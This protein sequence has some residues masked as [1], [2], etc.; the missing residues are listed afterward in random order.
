MADLPPSHGLAHGEIQTRE[1]AYP[2][3]DGTGLRGYLAYDDAQRGPRPGILVAPEFW[4]LNDYIRR[5]AR[6]LAALGYTALAL[7]MYG[8]GHETREPEEAKALMQAAT[9]SVEATRQRFEAALDLLL[10]QPE[11]DPQRVGAIGYC[12]GGKLVL[13]MARQGV[14]MAG[15]VSFHGRLTPAVPAAPGGVRARVLVEHGEADSMT[16]PEQLQAFEDEM[17]Q[18]GV[19]YRL[20]T[21]PGARHGFT[22]PQADERRTEGLDIG[23]QKEADERSWEDMKA[24]LAEVFRE[25]A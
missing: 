20:V 6:E 2:S 18:A 23:Y 4:G 3:A 5:R 24:F 14:P 21:H 7:D 25:R 11:V 13:D 1:L 16:T 15:V 12:F 9:A 8:D 17:R 19:D 22:N 10:R